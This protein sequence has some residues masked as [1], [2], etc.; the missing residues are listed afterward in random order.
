MKKQ[1]FGRKFKRD[2][3]ERKALFKGLLTN[4][5]L[6]ERIKTTE[7]KAK[8]IKGRAEKLVTRVKK[9]GVYD[10]S[11]QKYLTPPA[12]KKL[13]GDVASRF[14]TRQGGYTRIIRL[15]R[16]LK[17]NAS[18]AFIEW[19]EKNDTKNEKAR[20]KNKDDSKEEKPKKNTKTQK[21]KK[22]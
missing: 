12:A 6:K 1:V 3:N 10:T 9:T 11:L 16:R 14:P 8:A 4:L 13:V 2:V 7:D 21:E 22:K 15:G 17:D 20:T 18:M 19:V 5:V